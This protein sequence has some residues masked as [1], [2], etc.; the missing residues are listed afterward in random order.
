MWVAMGVDRAMVGAAQ[1]P[2]SIASKA[3]N[4]IRYRLITRQTT[5]K[6][7]RFCTSGCN[8]RSLDEYQTAEDG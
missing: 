7:V 6:I 5:R 8:Q 1:E 2:T 3:I 4:V